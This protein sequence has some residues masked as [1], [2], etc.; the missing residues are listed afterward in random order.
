M[1]RLE[2]GMIHFIAQFAVQNATALWEQDAHH[3]S[4][5]QFKRVLKQCQKDLETD[6]L[7][8]LDEYGADDLHISFRNVKNGITHCAFKLPYAE[9]LQMIMYVLETDQYPEYEAY[10]QDLMK[11]FMTKH[12][13]LETFDCPEWHH[14][15]TPPEITYPLYVEHNKHYATL[16]LHQCINGKVACAFH[17]SAKIDIICVQIMRTAIASY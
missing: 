16:T 8:V 10:I 5:K 1:R 6:K 9:F 3:M 7:I 17:H 15:E 11:R 13:Q 4:L 12:G 2:K 14:S